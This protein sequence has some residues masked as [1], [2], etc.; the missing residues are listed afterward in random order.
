MK[1]WEENTSQIYMSNS[2]YL[3]G[4]ISSDQSVSY[5]YIELYY[6]HLYMATVLHWFCDLI[7]YNIAFTINAE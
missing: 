1:L 6:Y 7:M 4:I 3:S 5:V 2:L